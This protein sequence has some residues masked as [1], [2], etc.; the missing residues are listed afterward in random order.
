MRRGRMGA[1]DPGRPLRFAQVPGRADS[2]LTTLC[3]PRWV[4]VGVG[5]GSPAPATR[6]RPPHDA[7]RSHES[8]GRPESEEAGP[9]AEDEWPRRV[10]RIPEQAPHP[11]KLA[12]VRA[13]GEV[14][15]EG[16]DGPGADPVPEAGEKGNREEAPE[17]GGERH[18]REAPPEDGERRNEGPL[19]PARVHEPAGRI[20]HRGIERRREA[21]GEADARRVES[22]GV[23]PEGDEDL[24]SGAHELHRERG[25]PSA[26]ERLAMVAKDPRDDRPVRLGPA[27][28]AHPR[29]PDEDDDQ[30]ETGHVEDRGGD[31]RGGEP[32]R[33]RDEPTRRR[34][35]E[36]PHPLNAGDRGNRTPAVRDRALAGHV[37]EPAQHEG[38]EPR[39]EH[40]GEEADRPGRGGE[41]EAGAGDADD[42]GSRRHRDL[43]AEAGD[44]DAGR[45]VGEH[46]A[47]PA[48]PEHRGGGRH[49]APDLEGVEGQQDKGR[50]VPDRDEDGRNEDREGQAPEG[51]PPAG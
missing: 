16:H 44:R 10:A 12:A 31:E 38:A 21:E 23:A 33:L 11:E 48:H 34:P 13:R 14:R 9:G 42:Q 19:A 15:P 36:E 37:V 26:R 20:E 49:P 29:A 7:H 5:A 43:V 45:N 47:E 40:E 18:E 30:H 1:A 28:G 22:D 8:E 2:R 50:L 4:A 35:H 32:E 25:A 46:G 17:A 3:C 27:P 6:R 39:P 41:G 51:G 24:A